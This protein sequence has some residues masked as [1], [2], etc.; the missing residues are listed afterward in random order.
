M[1]WSRVSELLYHHVEI[2]TTIKINI[3]AQDVRT[4][5]LFVDDNLLHNEQK[6]VYTGYLKALDPITKCAILC[7]IDCDTVTNNILILGQVI[8]KIQLS[9][10]SDTISASEVEQTIQKDN[11]SRQANHPYFVQKKSSTTKEELQ[12]R[13]D[14]ILEWL[15]RN[16]IPATLNEDGEEII[17]ADC[18]KLRPPYEESTDFIC[19]T[20]VV[21]KRIKQIVDNRDTKAERKLTV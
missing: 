16:R 3:G 13:R 6:L 14:D 21:M 20:R 8:D 4:E 19:P 17:I 2:S 7:A 18:V 5:F 11:L 10:S 15:S 1:D 9:C 12:N